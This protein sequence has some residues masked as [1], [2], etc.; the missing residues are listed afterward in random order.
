MQGN[1]VVF[2]LK[3]TNFYL[4]ALEKMNHEQE[5]EYKRKSTIRQLHV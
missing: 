5:T 3:K 4:F 1:V 2:G